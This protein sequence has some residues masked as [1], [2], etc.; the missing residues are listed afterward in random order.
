MWGFVLSLISLLLFGGPRANTFSASL[1]YNLL[2]LHNDPNLA[3]F[4]SIFLIYLFNSANKKFAA[5]FVSIIS[6]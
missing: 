6:F 1:N 2:F 3:S 5:V 4:I